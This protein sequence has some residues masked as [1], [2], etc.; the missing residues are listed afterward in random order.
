MEVCTSGVGGGGEGLFAKRQL[1]EGQTPGMA[2]K[3][4]LEAT[5]SQGHK[6]KKLERRKSKYRVGKMEGL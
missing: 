3:E 6:T 2:L 4:R 1:E 5:P